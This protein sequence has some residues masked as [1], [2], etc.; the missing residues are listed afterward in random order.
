MHLYTHACTPSWLHHYSSRCT[1]V[2]V[3]TYSRFSM[4][5]MSMCIYPH[6]AIHCCTHANWSMRLHT[7]I[8]LY[9]IHMCTHSP[10][11]L[12]NNFTMFLHIFIPM[13]LYNSLPV[14]PDI[15]AQLYSC[16]PGRLYT[17]PPIHLYS[18]TALHLYAHTAIHRYTLYA[19]TS[20]HRSIFTLVQLHVYT[21]IHPYIHTHVC[22]DVF[23]CMHLYAY[24]CT[25]TAIQLYKYTSCACTPESLH[26]YIHVGRYI[27]VPICQDTNIQL[28]CSDYR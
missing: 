13:N 6:M 8:P 11:C 21:P 19:Y 3:P 23:T 24:S 25:H 12:H 14:Y 4:L 10:V 26:I 18:Y 16:T 9:P 20:R 15:A 22:W 2:Y 28:T 5:C 1:C 7:Y 17:D 27:Y